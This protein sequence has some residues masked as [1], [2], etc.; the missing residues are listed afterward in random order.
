MPREGL[1]NGRSPSLKN[2]NTPTVMLLKFE[3]P[4]A[5]R[6]LRARRGFVSVVTGLSLSGIALGVAALIVVMSVMAGFREE[7]VGR[8]LGT[9]GHANIL[10]RPVPNEYAKVLQQNLMAVPEVTQV[11]PLVVGQAMATGNGQALGGVVRGMALDDILKTPFLSHAIKR[12]NLKNFASNT[13]VLGAVM[14]RGLG[15]DVGDTIQLLSPQGSQTVVGFIPRIRQLEVVAVFDIGMY[16]YDS[17]LL[18]MPM[19]D[20]QSFFK[21]GPFITTFEVKVSDP[22]LIMNSLD[23]L[24][25]AAGDGAQ[26]IPWTDNN[27]EF[28]SA[29]KVERNVMFIILTLIVLVAAFNIITGQMMTVNEKKR[30]IAILR[31]LGATRQQMAH[32][33]FL[34]GMMVGV[35]GT[36]GGVGLGIIIITNLNNIATI[37]ERSFGWDLFPDEIYFLSTLPSQVDWANVW[38]IALLGLLLSALASTLPA[39][40]ASRLDPVEGLRH[41]S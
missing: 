31:T 12:G 36:L 21:T 6:Y 1:Y 13:V 27:R 25:K 17:G 22:T 2:G 20:A 5:W 24:T 3:L 9:T 8:I 16:Q 29:L 18:L 34:G 7:L 28:F 11:T 4:V 37:L 40:R 38:W 26:V 23:R 35:A 39:V 10:V 14:A 30:D 33:F 32:V 19:I 15:V 41:E